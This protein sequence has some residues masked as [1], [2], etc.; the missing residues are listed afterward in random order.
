MNEPLISVLLT[1]SA[2]VLHPGEILDCEYQIDAVEASE[3]HAVEA[4][5]MSPTVSPRAR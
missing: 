5:V 4:S 1:N 3:I 2:N